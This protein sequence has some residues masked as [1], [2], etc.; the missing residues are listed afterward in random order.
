[1]GRQLKQFTC[2]IQTANGS[3]TLSIVHRYRGSKKGYTDFALQESE[4]PMPAFSLTSPE[5]AL[6]LARFLE[7]EINYQRA[8]SQTAPSF[9]TTP[10]CPV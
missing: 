6:E 9:E 1:M 5:S 8:S 7:E 2:P 10:E 3:S 4:Q